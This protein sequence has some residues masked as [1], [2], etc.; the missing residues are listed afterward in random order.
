MPDPVKIVECPRDGWQGLPVQ[1]PAEIKAAYLHNLIAAGFRHIDAVSFVSPAAIPQT[2]DSEAV[3]RLLDAP[4]NVEITGIV[5][6]AKG[7][8]RAIQTGRVQTL[9]FPY[10]VSPTFLERNQHQTQEEAL[11]AL[12]AIC[13]LAR[14]TGRNV[15]AYVSMAFGNPYDEPWNIDRVLEACLQ[16]VEAGA[17]EL[18]LADT[19]G[20]ASASLIEDT[21]ADVYPSCDCVELGVHLHSRPDQA[22]EKIRAAYAAGCRRFDSALGGVGGCPFAQD[23]LVA[24]IPTEILVPEL[25]SLGAT[26]PKLAPLEPLVEASSEIAHSFSS[27][28]SLSLRSA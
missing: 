13:R 10:S 11:R 15:V 19:V 8:E 20:L 12:A 9:G 16:V 6:N 4:P 25:R 28:P 26:L 18:C 2:A 7:A 27:R 21:I 22:G 14:Q 3:L 1:I 5:V 24:N 17:Q 23:A